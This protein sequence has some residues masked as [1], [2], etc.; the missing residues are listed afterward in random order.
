MDTLEKLQHYLEQKVESIKSSQSKK[1]WLNFIDKIIT[2]FIL[3]LREG[4]GKEELLFKKETVY[5]HD[6]TPI[7]VK[8]LFDR[9]IKNTQIYDKLVERLGQKYLIDE[10]VAKVWII[11]YAKYLWI[12]TK[13]LFKSFPSLWVEQVWSTH[14]EFSK[15]YQKFSKFLFGKTVYPHFYHLLED[16]NADLMTWYK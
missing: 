3:E 6:N 1:A 9:V 7:T 13:H 14:M 10:E 11:E 8:Q 5:L 4:A 16:C 2:C 12:F 15:E